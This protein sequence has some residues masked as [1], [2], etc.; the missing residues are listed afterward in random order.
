MQPLARD[1][2]VCAARNSLCLVYL[3]QEINKKLSVETVSDTSIHSSIASYEMLITPA[4]RIN[5]DNPN[6]SFKKPAIIEFA[7]NIELSEKD[8]A[9]NMVIPL[10]ADSESSEWKELGSESNCTVKSDR[11]SF[12]VTHFSL[13]AVI[14]RKPYP[15][16]TVEVK[17]SGDSSAPNQAT[18]PSTELTVPELPGFKVQIPPSSIKADSETDVTATILYDCPAVCSEDNRSRLASSCIELEPHGI[19]FTKPVSI[20]IPIPNY[21]EIKENHPD[22]QL[23]ILWHSDTVTDEEPVKHI[24][25]QDKGGQYVAVVQ[26][27]H[28]SKLIPMWS[29]RIAS[30]V[31]GIPFKIRTRC[32]VFMSQEILSKS[33][34]TFSIAIHFYSYKEKPH[35]MPTEYKHML[36][37]SN[38][39]KLMVSNSDTVQFEIEFNEEL[40][41]KPIVGNFKISGS[42]QK[43]FIIYLDG[44][45]E[46]SAGFPI[47]IL[48][49]GVKEKNEHTLTLIKVSS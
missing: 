22:A 25:S 41:C 5:A 14:S 9:N 33:R 38:L 2:Y 4:V 42:Q 35:P 47:G 10:C 48:S 12:E 43:S 49:I 11:I 39:L 8:Q 1:G 29:K 32:Q 17:P 3:P 34:L 7:K 37:D 28:F 30:R 13:Y 26:T 36:V 44:S 23:Q 45:V 27:N 31:F 24:V 19:T 15:K 21:A 18:A 6:L 46:L 16:S 20:S 40:K